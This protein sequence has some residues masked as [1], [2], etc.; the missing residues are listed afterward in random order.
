MGKVL[1]PEGPAHFSHLGH[2]RTHTYMHGYII[3]F[4][5]PVVS[6]ITGHLCDAIL[7][8]SK[9]AL[10]GTGLTI[11]IHITLMVLFLFSLAVVVYFESPATKSDSPCRTLCQK[12]PTK[13]DE[14][15]LTVSKYMA[16]PCTHS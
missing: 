9:Q 11:A 15:F 14:C 8:A 3:L 10:L 6:S 4:S 12:N 13:L 5:F 2:P 1:V 7:A 16:L